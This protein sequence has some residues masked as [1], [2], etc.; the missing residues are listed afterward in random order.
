MKILAHTSFIGTTGYANHAKSFFCALNK[1]HT[2]KVRNLTIGNSWNGMNNRPHDGEPY[3]TDEM[4]NMLIL[5]TLTRADGNGRI[6]EPMYDYKG[7]FVPDVHIVLMET[8]N[9]YFYED[10]EGYKI[11]YNV[12]ES[13]RYPDEFS[14]TW[15]RIFVAFKLWVTV[16]DVDDVSPIFVE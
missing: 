11:A 16:N 12:W 9:H 7:D 4:A 10:Y 3:F 15:T 1:Y 2:V 6:D 8:N 5:Q 13:T 14:R